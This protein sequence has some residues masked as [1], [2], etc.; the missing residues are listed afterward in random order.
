VN[1][2]DREWMDE[3]HHK[4]WKRKTTTPW[5]VART[6][7]HGRNRT[8]VADIAVD[9]YETHGTLYVLSGLNEE[10]A[11]YLVA[12]HNANL[13]ARRYEQEAGGT[14]YLDGERVFT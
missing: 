3:Q 1:A 13:K 4:N 8:I 14:I 5:Y 6:R 12:E 2:S 7:V 9:D 10:F 11:E